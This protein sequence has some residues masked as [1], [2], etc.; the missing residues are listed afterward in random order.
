[1]AGLV[2]SAE[3]VRGTIMSGRSFGSRLRELRT[4]R[5][6][7]T[8]ADV[9][10]IVKLSTAYLSEMENGRRAPFPDSKLVRLLEEWNLLAHLEELRILS[11]ME[12]GFVSLPVRDCSEE[13]VARVAE[14]GRLAVGGLTGPQWQA[15]LTIARQ[16]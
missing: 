11:A 15:I 5:A 7:K 16:K 1:M 9:A 10:E 14:F 6:F 13:T 4:E 12:S 3:R 2:S 8:L